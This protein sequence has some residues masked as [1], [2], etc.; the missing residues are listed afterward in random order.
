MKVLMFGWE[1]P[2]YNQGGLGTACHGLVNGLLEHNTHVYFVLPKMLGGGQDHPH[3]SVNLVDASQPIYRTMKNGKILPTIEVDSSLLP[4]QNS[5]AY[6]EYLEE[7][8]RR[9]I[10]NANPSHH[11]KLYGKDLLKEV[12]RYAH[13]AAAI[14]EVHDHD[15]IHAHDWMAYPAGEVAKTQSGKPMIAHVH[16]TEFDRTGGNPNQHVYD[17]ERRGMHAAD[18][19]IAVSE[20]TKQKI[21]EHYGIEPDKIEVVHN[22]VDIDAEYFSKPHHLTEK[23]KIVLFLGRMT[24]QKGPDYFIQMAKKVLDKKKR[25]KFVM[26]GTGD[27][28]KHIIHESANLGIADKILFTGFLRG[29][30]IDRVYQSADLYV[31]PS[32]SEPFGITPLEAIKNGTPV[33][34]SK[35]SGVSEVI[36]NALKVDFWDVD[37]MA[38]K[39]LSVLSYPPLHN[40]LKRQSK[41]ELKRMSWRKQAEKVKGVYHKVVA[42]S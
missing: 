42:K 3:P 2:P 21:I 12:D 20:F 19:I 23:D 32:V 34:I 38:S 6:D 1:F 4:Y 39:V 28:M 8:V 30:E 13:K 35:Q 31:M 9:K 5:A 24:L 15:V 37:A 26:A 27:M 16:A 33:L 25:V 29:D 7:I 36:V 14:A 11:N 17:I 41:G 40:Q 10:G 18:H 22:A